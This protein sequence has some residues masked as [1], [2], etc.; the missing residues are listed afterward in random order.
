ME[1]LKEEEA[2]SAPLISC[3]RDV[4]VTSDL[5]VRIAFDIDHELGKAPETVR[6]TCYLFWHRT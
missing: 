3:C 2:C 4:T 6:V 1:S 5:I